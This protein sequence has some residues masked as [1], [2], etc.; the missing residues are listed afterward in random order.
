M[1]FNIIINKEA[2]FYFFIQ[3]LSCWHDNCRKSY[4]SFWINETDSALS[5]NE[6]NALQTF[7]TIR[8]KYNFKGN[9]EKYFYFPD[10]MS[11]NF[12][13][14]DDKNDLED[15]F[16]IFKKRFELIYKKEETKLKEWEKILIE[17]F[18]DSKTNTEIFNVLNTFFDFKPE[19]TTINVILLMS[20][21]DMNGGGAN[22]DKHSVTLEI[23]ETTTNKINEVMSIAWHE[24]IHL[25]YKSKIMTVLINSG[26]TVTE[27]DAVEETINSYL[28]P[29]GVLAKKFFNIK[30]DN[31]ASVIENY[32]NDRK[33]L[34]EN[35]IKKIK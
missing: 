33:I 4:N 8:S 5:N 10:N 13:L 1:N 23:S 30:N 28:F 35:L 24:I 14:D 17:K 29:K 6:Q 7:K 21:P 12:F 34:D 31:E 16:R 11:S 20:S 26:M 19:N 22:I 15:I 27:A 3:N 25:L 2:N 18:L 9:F 32:L